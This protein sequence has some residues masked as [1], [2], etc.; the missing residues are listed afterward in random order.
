VLVGFGARFGP[1]C[2]GGLETHRFVVGWLETHR[3]GIR[4]AGSPAGCARNAGSPG[5]RPDPDGLARHHN[6]RKAPAV[7]CFPSR[8][9]LTAPQVT[10][11]VVPRRCFPSRKGL[12]APQVT[13]SA[14]VVVLCVT[15]GRSAV[16]VAG[17]AS[18][19]GRTRPAASGGRATAGPRP[20]RA[21][22][23]LRRCSGASSARPPDRFRPS[24]RRRCSPSRGGLPQHVGDGVHHAVDVVAVHAV[25]SE[26]K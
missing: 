21:V 12:T 20:H 13:R 18:E 11:S 6:W 9:G 10:R 8:V 7:G 14:T 24:R 16:R 26:A 3:D 15:S 4:D 25:Q 5:G 22:A 17:D 2:C 1:G 23:P 19:S